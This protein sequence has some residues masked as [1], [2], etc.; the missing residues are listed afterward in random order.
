MKPERIDK[1]LPSKIII[2]IYDQNK[3]KVI[4]V[5]DPTKLK[6]LHMLKMNLESTM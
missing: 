6:A 1:D 4:V 2:G 3:L 5:L